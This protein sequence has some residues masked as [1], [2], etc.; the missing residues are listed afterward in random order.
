[1]IYFVR[2]DRTD[3]VKIGYTY[4]DPSRRLSDLQTGQADPLRLMGLADGDEVTER[5]WHARF[6]SSR[7]RGEWFRL[8]PPLACSIALANPLLREFFAYAPALLGLVGEFACRPHDGSE[9]PV[10]ALMHETDGGLTFFEAGHLMVVAR[11]LGHGGDYN[12]ASIED[13]VL[14][15]A[16]PCSVPGCGCKTRIR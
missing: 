15:L 6:A 16:L 7:V 2:Q 10:R 8:T 14:A 9:C 3:L 5:N 1:M 4:S 13:A 12:A 11:E